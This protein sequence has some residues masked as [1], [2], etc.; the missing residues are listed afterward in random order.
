MVEKA[1]ADVEKR[2]LA[3]AG[4]ELLHTHDDRRL[5][6]HSPMQCSLATIRLQVHAGNP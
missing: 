5:S 6:Y 3:T 4:G 1:L 2:S